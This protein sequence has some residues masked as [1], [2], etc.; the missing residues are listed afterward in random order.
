MEIW[1]RQ[2][3]SSAPR[4]TAALALPPRPLDCKVCSRRLGF[5]SAPVR[6]LIPWAK[7]TK[8]CAKHGLPELCAEG[9]T[10]WVKQQQN[11]GLHAGPRTHIK[12]AIISSCYR[13][14]GG[15]RPA[16]TSTTST[17]WPYDGIARPG[18]CGT[19]KPVIQPVLRRQRVLAD[20]RSPRKWYR[21]ATV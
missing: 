16:M 3:R 12:N 2:V 5:G 4:L 11:A 7:R 8:G 15:P 6:G 14:V 13:K 9:Q 10:H 21:P 18:T 17:P 19:S 20:R 1:S